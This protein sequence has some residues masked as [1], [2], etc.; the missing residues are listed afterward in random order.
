M[1][2]M[3]VLLLLLS[4]AAPASPDAGDKAAMVS[5]LNDRYRC[6]WP[7]GRLL[8]ASS[9][10]ADCSLFAGEDIPYA[11]YRNDRRVNPIVVF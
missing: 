9:D 6:L 3:S 1:K 2:T 8:W 7:D 11:L 5:G 4:G 10:N